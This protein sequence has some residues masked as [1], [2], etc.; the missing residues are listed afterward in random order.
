MNVITQTPIYYGDTTT[1]I[2]ATT[3]QSTTYEKNLTNIE[4]E[5]FNDTEIMNIETST[6]GESSSYIGRKNTISMSTII[7]AINKTTPPMSCFGLHVDCWLR[8]VGDV[9]TFKM[10]VISNKDEYKWPWH[11]SVYVW[12]KYF[13]TAT[14]L[15]THWLLTDAV[16][17]KNVE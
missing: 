7:D 1:T 17:L 10:N 5:T 11:A 14:L 6:D 9:S 4:D 12:G 8:L 16:F 3:P 13:C 15:D 2:A